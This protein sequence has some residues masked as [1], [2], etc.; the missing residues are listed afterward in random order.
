LYLA[1]VDSVSIETAK[2]KCIGFLKY[3]EGWY[4]GDGNTFQ[5]D[6]IKQIFKYMEIAQQ[7]DLH[8]VEVNPELDGGI[9]LSIYYDE[10]M[11]DIISYSSKDNIMW[12]QKATEEVYY[13]ESVSSD[14]VKK[15]IQNFKN[16]E[17]M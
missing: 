3:K 4:E 14:A 1:L 15:C 5:L 17:L 8:I 7:N 6:T 9:T 12:L 16:E 13:K 2:E 10:Y 11:M